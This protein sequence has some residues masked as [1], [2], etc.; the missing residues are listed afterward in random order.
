[1]NKQLITIIIIAVLIIGAWLIFKQE[2]PVVIPNNES[3]IEEGG[4]L[5]VEGDVDVEFSELKEFTVNG[6]DFTFSLN[7]IRVNEGD[8]VRINFINT[9]GVHD[10]RLEGYNVGTKVLQSGQMEIVE[11][12]ADRKGTFEYFCSVGSHRALGMKGNLIVE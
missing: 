12:V 3:E 1:M 7:E 9:A 5:E 6:N 8:T 2:S 10:W 4:N 11:F